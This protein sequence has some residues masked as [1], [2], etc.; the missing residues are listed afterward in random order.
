MIRHW[1]DHYRRK[2]KAKG[3]AIIAAIFMVV[4]V[5]VL[6]LFM[7]RLSSA[8]NKSVALELLH[9]RAMNAARSGID[10][11]AYNVTHGAACGTGTQA[12]T[13]SEADL[14]G[15]SVSLS[16]RCH[17]HSEGGN[18]VEV[19]EVTSEARQGSYTGN[20]DYVFRRLQAGMVRSS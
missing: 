15:F 12:I 5:G 9:A 13:L 16:W 10:V 1:Q 18:T 2:E 6:V 4:V 19:F 8:Q 17:S 7:E 11:M 20:Q 3:F 14:S